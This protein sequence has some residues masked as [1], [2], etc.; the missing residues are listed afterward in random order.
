MDASADCALFDNLPFAVDW[1]AALRP[2]SG[3]CQCRATILAGVLESCFGSALDNSIAIASTGL[4]SSAA[5]LE[6]SSLSVLVVELFW[7]LVLAI[8]FS[9]KG[10]VASVR[11]APGKAFAVA[12]GRAFGRS[13]LET[14]NFTTTVAARPIKHNKAS[15]TV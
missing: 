4:T 9:A 5:S 12:D 10:A 8:R 11:A 13:L 3:S 14:P 1:A 7:S 2:S 15:Q 6:T